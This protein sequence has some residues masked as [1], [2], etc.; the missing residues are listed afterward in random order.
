MTGQTY[1]PN[2]YAIAQRVTGRDIGFLF[3]N[4]AKWQDAEALLKEGL[5]LR[6]G[7]TLDQA[8]GLLRKM[9]ATVQTP[10]QLD[11]ALDVVM[12]TSEVKE[13]GFST[14]EVRR[15]LPLVLPIA[16]SKFESAAESASQ[17]PQVVA[18]YRNVDRLVVD[19][20]ALLDPIQGATGDCYLIASMIALAWTNPGRLEQLFASSGFDARGERSFSWQF[21]DEMRGLSDAVTVAGTVPTDQGS[22]LYARSSEPTEYWPALLEKAYVKMIRNLNRNPEPEDYLLIA[23]GDTPQDA[24]QMLVGGR[25]KLDMLNRNDNLFVFRHVDGHLGTA[26]GVMDRPVMVSTMTSPT[27]GKEVSKETGLRFDH[28]YAVLGVIKSGDTI[29]HVVIRDPYGVPNEVKNGFRWEPWLPE[30]RPEV[31]LNQRGV[32]AIDRDLFFKHFKNIGW[33]NLE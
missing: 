15:V 7:R 26:S 17:A 5:R 32:M 23:H 18:F 13:W 27:G 22:P 31:E 20:T 25:A 10:I 14:D 3:G 30:G 24:C 21:H 29:E 6:G 2:P 8:L 4:G 33:V 16:D 12:R 9:A 28:V 1:A 11:Q 19:G